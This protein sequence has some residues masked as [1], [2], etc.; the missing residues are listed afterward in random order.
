MP[1]E[2][3]TSD[4]LAGLLRKLN[5]LISLAEGELATARFGAGPLSSCQ[6]LRAVI[7]EQRNVLTTDLH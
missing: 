3:M 6:S 4:L 2:R 7:P 5:D 1:D